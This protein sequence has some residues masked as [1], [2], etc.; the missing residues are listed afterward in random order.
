[1][2]DLNDYLYVFHGA[3]ASYKICETELHGN[4]FNSMPNIWIR[5]AYAQGFYCKN[6]TK[7]SVNMFEQIEKIEYIYESVVE[8]SYQKN[9]TRGKIPTVL[10]T[11]GKLDDN[12]PSQL[13]NTR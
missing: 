6:I 4:L 10:N 12:P 11:A 1:M 5:Q 13:L 9:P 2:I 7:K 3:K 8:P